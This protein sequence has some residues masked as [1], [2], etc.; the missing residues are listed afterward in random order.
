MHKMVYL[1][2]TLNRSVGFIDLL[3]GIGIRKRG[4][5]WGRM[6]SRWQCRTY[7]PLI[8]RSAWFTK[9]YMEKL[10][11]ARADILASK[12]AGADCSAVEWI[13]LL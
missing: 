11:E 1:L 12:S 3:R 7:P 8:N 9:V 5:D 4:D 10:L 13:V 6:Q 2:F